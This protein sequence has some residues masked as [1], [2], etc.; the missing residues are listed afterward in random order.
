MD[1]L[2]PVATNPEHYR[3]VFENER[4]RVLEYRDEPGTVTTPHDH[5]DSVMVTLSGFR[6]RLVAGGRHRDVT[7]EPGQAL[8]LDAQRHHGE[9]IGDT[10][11]HVLL[12]ELKDAARDGAEAAGTG[13]AGPGPAD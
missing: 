3:P 13:P 4:V 7:L 6:R 10:G 11:T 9:N 5:P 12:I 2:D 8:W 1:R